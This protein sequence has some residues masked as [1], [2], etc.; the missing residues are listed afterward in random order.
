[1]Q[2]NEVVKDA[3]GRITELRCTFDP[4]TKSGSPTAV[5]RKVKG[6]IHWVSATQC[7]EVEVRLYDRLF[8]SE[9]PE[10][11]PP[12]KT[13][14]DNLNPNSIQIVRAMV[15]PEVAKQTAGA[16]VQFERNG[17]FCA[18]VVDS[19]PGA[20]VFNRIVSLKDAWARITTRESKV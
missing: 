11:A 3:S 1:M 5:E 17:Y 8:L 9:D 15:E 20:P 13:F 10:D 2:C 12:G 7:A 6:T 18:D 4:T 16:A 19:R 14:L